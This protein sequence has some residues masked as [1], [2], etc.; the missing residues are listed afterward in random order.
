MATSNYI[1]YYYQGNQQSSAQQYSGYQTSLPPNSIR[2]PSRQYQQPPTVTQP[3]ENMSYPGQFYSG[4]Q[5]T[6]Y[7]SGQGSSWES[8][9]YGNNHESGNA[10]EVLRN[11]SNNAYNPRMS[12]GASSAGFTATNSAAPRYSTSTSQAKQ[13][14]QMHASQSHGNAQTH[15]Q[16][17]PRSVNTNRTQT[18]SVGRGLPFPATAYPSQRGQSIY[19]QQPHR[20]ASPAQPH[21]AQNPPISSSNT[22]TAAITATAA[23]SYNNYNSRQLPAMDVSRGAQNSYSNTPVSAP[24]EQEPTSNHHNQGATTVDPTAVYDPWP[25]YQR[26]QEAQRAQIAAEDVRA[27]E[28]RKAEEARKEEE[29]KRIEADKAKASSA[30]SSEEAA[31]DAGGIEAEIRAMMAK[32]RELNGKDPVLLARIWEEERKAKAPQSPQ[33]RSKAAPQPASTQPAPA[34]A[35]PVANS[36][37]PVPASTFKAQSAF[38]PARST[39]A[40][41]WP[42]EKKAELAKATSTYL[43]QQNPPCFTV[44]PETLLGMLDVNPS[45]IELCE[46]LEQMGLKLD[47]AALAKTLLAAVPDLNSTSRQ[48]KPPPLRPVPAVA[49]KTQV[50]TPAAAGRDLVISDNKEEAAR[51]RTFEALIDLTAVSEEDDLPPIKKLNSGSALMHMDEPAVVPNNFQNAASMPESPLDAGPFHSPAITESQF[52]NIDLVEPLDRKKALRRNRYNSKTIARDVL[53]ACGRHPDERHLNAHLEALIKR[54]PGVE[55]NSDLSTLRWDMLDPGR[56]PPG[57]YRDQ[58]QAF[59]GEEA[60]DELDSDEE[61]SVQPAPVT[62]A[63]PRAGALPSDTNPFETKRRGEPPRHSFPFQDGATTVT[64]PAKPIKPSYMSASEPRPRPS[65]SGGGVGHAAFKS[66]TQVSPDRQPLPKTRG[67]PV[68]WRKAI[69]GSP[70]AQASSQTNQHRPSQPSNLRFVVTEK[71]KN[72]AVMVSSRSPSAA[73]ATPQYQSFKCKWQGCKADL[74]NLETLQ[75]HVQKVHS[76]VTPEGVLGCLWGD[77]GRTVASVDSVTNFLVDRSESVSFANEGQWNEHLE[78]KHLNPISWELGDGPA[79]GLSDAHDLESYLSD[80]QGRRVTPRITAEFK[81]TNPTSSSGRG[82]P[83]KASREHEAREISKQMISQKKRI[84][85]PGMDRGGSALVNEK[86][87]RGFSNQPDTEEEFV[88]A[89]D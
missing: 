35:L 57:Y 77:C 60:D 68:G 29:R 12:T 46:Q 83:P 34:S 8:S 64:T 59:P 66:V 84:G 45:Y 33:G 15:A 62:N 1:P 43:N 88:D 13:P 32:M 16:P 22:R 5:G 50:P 26:M 67:R 80:A 6:T 21:Y 78:I 85:G 82:M 71:N 44:T 81:V 27:K 73:R 55:Y 70:A 72:E 25:E 28:N 51:K 65:P 19:S 42:P 31:P 20:S 30:S 7:G 47:R 76:K 74:H 38:T 69:H 36:H 14:Q 79:S 49:R 37:V 56:P 39:R 63:E 11:M 61:R 23:T 18:P 10:A 3:T 24:A 54:I 40:T 75:K 4:D 9:N 2:Q 17:R 58:S 86:R 52:R 48:A 89:E 53:L 41:I 87:R